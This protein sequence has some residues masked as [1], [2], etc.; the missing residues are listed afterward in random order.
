MGSGM[1][2][3]T[4]RSFLYL[5]KEKAKDKGIGHKKEEEVLGFPSGSEIRNVISMCC[6]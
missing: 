2:L 1:L 6:W 5:E 4:L 3:E